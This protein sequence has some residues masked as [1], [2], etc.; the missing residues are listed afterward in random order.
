MMT[1]KRN[2][3]ITMGIGLCGAVVQI[4]MMIGVPGYLYDLFGGK[5]LSRVE[6]LDWAEHN[7]E[8]QLSLMVLMAIVA[9]VYVFKTSKETCPY[10]SYII[11]I[12]LIP[13]ILESCLWGYVL[14]LAFLATR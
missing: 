11:G 13:L 14:I 3:I 4:M 10:R 12:Y 1:N 9:L 7:G 2:Q 6:E 5:P 8:A